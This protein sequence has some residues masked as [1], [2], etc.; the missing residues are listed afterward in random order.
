VAAFAGDPYANRNGYHDVP[1]KDPHYK[2]PLPKRGRDIN[3]FFLFCLS[4]I[5]GLNYMYIGL[6]KRG[7][8]FMSMFFMLIF[9]S[10]TLHT[11]VPMF[12]LFM[13]MC[14]SFF[15]GFKIRR[16]ILNGENVPDEITDVTT[17]FNANK[18]IITIVFLM[19]LGTAVFDHFISL[20]ADSIGSIF[21]YGSYYHMY[22]LLSLLFGIAIIGVG[23][24]MILRA[25]NK[26][27]RRPRPDD[28]EGHDG[29]YSDRK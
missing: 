24:I 1:H 17:F 5:P 18:S 21:G 19:I 26:K 20:F 8:F 22:N 13:E 2:P 15:D 28:S 11:P 7:M 9:I 14:Y 25:I 27:D 29:Y 6:M 3:V 12:A 16:Q 10:S 23:A 4:C